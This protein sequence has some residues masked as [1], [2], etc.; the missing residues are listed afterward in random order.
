MKYMISIYSNP[1][2]WAHPTFMHREGLSDADREARMAQFGALMQEISESGELVTGQPLADPAEAR[3]VRAVNGELTTVDGPFHTTEEQ[4]VGY[5]VVEC[6]SIDRAVEIAS[7][8]PDAH[9]GATEVRA[10]M[11]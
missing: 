2:P 8:F 3:T 10:F 7:R 9:D 5:F 11:E 1:K 4:L 6:E